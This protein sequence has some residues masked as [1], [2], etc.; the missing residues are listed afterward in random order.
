MVNAHILV[1]AIVLVVVVTLIDSYRV[2]QLGKE[3]LRLGRLV[4]EVQETV[5]AYNKSPLITTATPVVI[6]A[7]SVTSTSSREDAIVQAVNDLVVQTETEKGAIEKKQQNSSNSNNPNNTPE[8]QEEEDE[9]Q[10]QQ[11]QNVNGP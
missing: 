6:P 5:N 3:V 10:Q 2:Y 8:E 11:Q 1:G 9:Q 7:T 4:A